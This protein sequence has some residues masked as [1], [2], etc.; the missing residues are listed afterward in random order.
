MSTKNE[1]L[2]NLTTLPNQRL[3]LKKG[4]RVV[5]FIQNVGKDHV[6]VLIPY[7][8]NE[9]RIAKRTHHIQGFNWS[10]DKK[11]YHILGGMRKK[12]GHLQIVRRNNLEVVK[13]D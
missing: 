4:N 3:R 9:D 6:E 5:Y 1:T 13:G 10:G 2:P 7:T 12:A 8:A 11:R